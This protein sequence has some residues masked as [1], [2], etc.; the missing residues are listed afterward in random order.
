VSL[1]KTLRVLCTRNDL[2]GSWSGQLGLPPRSDVAQQSWDQRPRVFC[3]GRAKRKEQRGCGD[4]EANNDHAAGDGKVDGVRLDRSGFELPALD[5]SV[6]GLAVVKKK[7]A[8]LTSIA[9]AW[10]CKVG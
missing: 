2:R 5:A 9:S 6:S 10:A 8:G 4:A 1:G 3:F 7:A